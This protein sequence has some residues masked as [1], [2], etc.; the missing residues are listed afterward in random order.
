MR[1]AGDAVEPVEIGSRTAIEDAAGIAIPDGADK[2]AASARIVGEE[3]FVD[4]LVVEP[5][6]RTAVQ[7]NSSGSDH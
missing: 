2:I 7:P 1:T 6:H 4:S 5:G 3:F